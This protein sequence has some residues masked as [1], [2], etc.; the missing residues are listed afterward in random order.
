LAR[1]AGFTERISILETTNLPL[2]EV[3]F[4]L[5][6]KIRTRLGAPFMAGREKLQPDIELDA[7]QLLPHTRIGTPKR[8]GQLQ[9]E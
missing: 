3:S 7:V 2:A 8:L 5:A 4:L 9:R 1:A 6:A